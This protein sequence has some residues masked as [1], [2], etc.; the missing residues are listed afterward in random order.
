MFYGGPSLAY[1]AYLDEFGHIGPYVSRQDPRHN[2]SP[3]F[4]LAGFV[5]PS[6]QVRG[7]GTWF[8]QR[9]CELLAF[10]I[11]RSE[12]HPALWE[13]KG[14]SLY[15]VTNVTRYAELRKFTNR[16]FNKIAALDGFLFYVGIRKTEP[17]GVHSP[18][19]LYQAILREAIKRIDEFCASDCQPPED[20]VLILDEHDQR[21]QL[22]TQAARSMY[23]RRNRGDI[24]S[25][26]RS[27]SKAIAIKR[28]KQR[29]GLP[30]WWGVSP[31]PGPT[32][33]L[34]PRIKCSVSTSGTAS[35]ASTEGVESAH[36][37]E[38]ARASQIRERGAPCANTLQHLTATTGLDRTVTS[39]CGVEAAVSDGRIARARY[40]SYL[41]LFGAARVG[42]PPPA[43]RPARPLHVPLRRA[44]ERVRPGFFSD[45]G[46]EEADDPSDVL[47]PVRPDRRMGNPVGVQPPRSGRIGFRPEPDH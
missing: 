44:A 15:T 19:R 7:F 34:I 29:I 12:L 16:L 25:N 39:D 4:G 45:H 30:D 38:P 5:L 43:R 6:E 27:I 13:K 11:D 8:F 33:T 23:A 37:G 36:D 26:R 47:D 14:S 24:S 31:Q 32:R 28:S 41:A 17:P 2:D 42:G 46:P 18:N 35:M 10:E 20:F 3:V 21:S 22:I 9:K 40:E 1:F